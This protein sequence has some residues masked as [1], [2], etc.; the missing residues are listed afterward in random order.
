M[1]GFRFD[2]QINY[3]KETSTIYGFLLDVFTAIPK[4]LRDALDSL[5]N[6]ID[7]LTLMYV[8]VALVY[9]S[10]TVHEDTRIYHTILG[11]TIC[12]KIVSRPNNLSLI[13]KFFKNFIVFK[14]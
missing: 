5:K 6:F 9:S 10:V 11:I 1:C 4:R 3:R 14:K 13:L 8:K 7:A 12:K 2:K